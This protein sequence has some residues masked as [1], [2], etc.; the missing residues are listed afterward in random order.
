MSVL[1]KR[2]AGLEA[3]LRSLRPAPSSE[4]PEALSWLGWVTDLELDRLEQAFRQAMVAG[5]ELT[6]L[7]ALDALKIELAATERRAMDWPPRREDLEPYLA[8]DHPH[9]RR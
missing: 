7:E 1:A 5:R 8:I 9:W 6:E 3:R 2:L 4:L